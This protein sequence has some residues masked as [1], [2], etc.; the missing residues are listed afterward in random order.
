M[1]LTITFLQASERFLKQNR[2]DIKL[3]EDG[4]KGWKIKAKFYDLIA[5]DYFWSTP[6]S[7]F[8]LEVVHPSRKQEKKKQFNLLKYGTEYPQQSDIIKEKIRQ[9]LIANHNVTNVNNIRSKRFIT[10]TGQ[11]VK[12]WLDEQPEP[13]PAWITLTQYFNNE[14]ISLD[15]LEK[16]VNNYKSSKSSLE[17]LGKN[18]FKV[19]HFNKYVD[20][21]LRYRPDFKLSDM[22]YVNVDGLYWH[23]EHQKNKNYHFNLRIDFENKNLRI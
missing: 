21:E 7:V 17:L 14:Q 1:A 9:T 19:E 2:S 11:Y 3:C 16:Y 13:K 8:K 23:S 20:K 4:Y 12:E 18:L 10:E 6:Y 22:I 15:K 5:E